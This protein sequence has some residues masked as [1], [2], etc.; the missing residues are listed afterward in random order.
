MQNTNL[1]KK[2]Q[3]NSNQQDYAGCLFTAKMKDKTINEIN[4]IIAKNKNHP[5][6]FIKTYDQLFTI[7]LEKGD[8][9]DYE[10]VK[11]LLKL[12]Y[13]IADEIIGE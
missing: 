6:R 13:L 1:D 11:D 9:K 2:V 5:F 12:C 8:F 7:G 3:K 10:V 4:E